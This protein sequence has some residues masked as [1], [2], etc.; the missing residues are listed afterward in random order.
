MK[1]PNLGIIRELA[2]S[3]NISLKNISERLGISPAALQNIM[4]NNGT[5]L[6]T[7]GKLADIFGVSI[8]VFFEGTTTPKPLLQKTANILLDVEYKKELVSAYCFIENMMDSITID[9]K[10]EIYNLIKKRFEKIDKYQIFNILGK[11]SEN[12][13]LDLLSYIDEIEDKTVLKLAIY[14]IVY[15]RSGIEHF[16]DFWFKYHK[17]PNRLQT[18]S[19]KEN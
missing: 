5:S 16:A 4:R 11:Y 7:L 18:I 15:K 10:D 19:L 6:E 1:K 3:Q 17:L 2:K 14:R 12:E 9:D 8:D 13:F